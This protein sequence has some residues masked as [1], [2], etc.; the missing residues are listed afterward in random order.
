MSETS[1]HNYEIGIWYSFEEPIFVNKLSFW[2]RIWN[3]IKNLLTNRE[4]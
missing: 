2:K 4:Y 3:W 1:N